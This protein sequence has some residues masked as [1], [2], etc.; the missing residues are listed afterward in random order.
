MRSL[1]VVVLV[2]AATSWAYA[3]TP[4]DKPAFTA[5]PEELMAAAK[6]APV[7]ER[8]GVTLHED[9]ED[10]FDERGAA[11][12][13]HARDRARGD[14]RGGQELGHDLERLEPVERGPAEGAR[15]DDQ[16]DAAR[17]NNSSIRRR[18]SRKRIA[19]AKAATCAPIS[20]SPA[21]TIVEEEISRVNREPTLGGR[22]FTY[23]FSGYFPATDRALDGLRCRP[24]AEDQR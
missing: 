3:G 15:P 9:T 19:S 8:G 23:V 24:R 6:T 20:W 16:R 2:A 11:D 10:S 1:Q 14:R 7:T 17:C 4:L 18:S 21:G 5:T 12:R 22:A 13:A